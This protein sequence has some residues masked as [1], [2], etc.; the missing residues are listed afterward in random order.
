MTRRHRQHARRVRYPARNAPINVS[1]GAGIIYTRE[2][3]RPE[4]RV[5]FTGR[6]FGS[7]LERPVPL[8]TS[9]I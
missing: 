8:F 5:Y 9:M 3:R 6:R 4:L 2:R 7:I 1:L